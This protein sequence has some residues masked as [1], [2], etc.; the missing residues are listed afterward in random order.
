MDLGNLQYA[1]GAK[2]KTKRVGRGMGSGHGKTSCRGHKGQKARTGS[3]H[4]A[5]F[6]GGQMPL[7]RRIPK[8][9]FFNIYRKAYQVVNVGDLKRVAGEKATL[10]SLLEANLIRN[11]TEPL[12]IL[13]NGEISRAL[14][15]SAHAFSKSAIQ[16]IEAAGGKVNRLC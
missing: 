6:E 5:W 11:L 9:G 16:K 15:V 10:E 12:K 2:K 3:G 4:R 14:E 1:E 8:R 7:Q 13:G